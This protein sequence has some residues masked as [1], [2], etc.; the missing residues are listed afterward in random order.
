MP[1]DAPTVDEAAS[2]GALR[3]RVIDSQD[4]DAELR[5]AYNIGFLLAYSMNHVLD[6][7]DNN[8]AGLPIEGSV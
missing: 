7:I 8:P 6:I 4:K 2:D 3:G 5:V 1:S